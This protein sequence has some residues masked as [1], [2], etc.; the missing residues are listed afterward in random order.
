MPL[1][2]KGG[3]IRIITL[4][5]TYQERDDRGR[6]LTQLSWS[7]NFR[8]CVFIGGGGGGG[9]TPPRSVC[10]GGLKG[11]KKKNGKHEQ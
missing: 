11:S 2:V 4:A 9:I 1:H 7:L 6:G 3:T 8:K 10:L 5:M